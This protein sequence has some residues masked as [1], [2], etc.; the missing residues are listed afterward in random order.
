MIIIIIYTNCCNLKIPFQLF[1]YSVLMIIFNIVLRFIVCPKIND[2]YSLLLIKLSI[3]L[4]QLSFDEIK[5]LL[6]YLINS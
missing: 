1:K 5:Q 6:T 3:H 4:A 2:N